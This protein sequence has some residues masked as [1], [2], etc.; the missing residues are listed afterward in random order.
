MKR[1]LIQSYEEARSEVAEL[2]KIGISQVKEA[3]LTE[4]LNTDKPYA[5]VDSICEKLTGFKIVLPN[6]IVFVDRITND[7]PYFHAEAVRILT[8][9]ESFRNKQGRL[10][11]MLS[12][13]K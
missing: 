8:V 12:E 9:V 10:A 2:C 11:T 3:V 6:N 7:D 1:K 4:C 13:V 5:R